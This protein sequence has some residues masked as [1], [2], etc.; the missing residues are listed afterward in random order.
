MSVL[1]QSFRSEA[2]TKTSFEHHLYGSIWK[3]APAL[4][5]FW[6]VSNSEVAAGKKIGI[7]SVCELGGN[8]CASALILR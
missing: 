8:E 7:Y 2:S 6:S 4:P 1:M 5:L 3:N